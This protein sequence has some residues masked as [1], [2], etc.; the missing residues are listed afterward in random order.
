LVDARPVPPSRRL[1]N[2]LLDDP[3]IG[4]SGQAQ[5]IETHISWVILAEEYV[6]KIKKPVKL[7]FLDFSS[8]AARHRA[9]LEELRLNRRLLAEY[10]LDL[11]SIR[12]SDTKPALSGN[13]PIIDYAV[14]MRR[15]PPGAVLSP[16][17]APT[18]TTPEIDA[19]AELLAHFHAGLPVADPQAP[20]G[21]PE[22][23]RRPTEET[24]SELRALL[25]E[26]PAQA[27][28]NQIGDFLDREFERHEGLMDRRRLDGFVRECHGDLH[29]GNLARIE[30]RLVP[31]D[32]LEF[33]PGLRWID[34]LSEVAFLVM[35]L[36]VNR[37][38]HAGFRFLNRY[39]DV[40]GDY[41]GLPV[42]PFY[43]GYRAAVRAKV[44]A[45]G[46]DARSAECRRSIG[47]LLEYAANP[48]AGLGP[49]LV[50]VCGIS[51]SGKSYLAGR[52]A[53]AMPAIHVRS[54]VERKR[55]FGLG[56][57]A[58]T[59][60][61]VDGG[62]YAPEASRRT[63]ERLVEVAASVLAARL[64]VI[65]DATQ[66]RRRHRQPFLSLAQTLGVPSVILTCYCDP[67]LLAERVRRRTAAGHDPS[68]ADYGIALRQQS[69]FETPGDDEASMV[70]RLDTGTGIDPDPL[71]SR[72][73]QLVND[74][75]T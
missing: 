45:L 38:D 6:Y 19:L 32:A 47:Q 43:L 50:L 44:G 60:A 65:V 75:A 58:R 70:L 12:G 63:Y 1:V 68:E 36:Q 64:P 30:G 40:T 33:D 9:C 69:E 39:L 13:G 24:V 10:Y 46:P 20:W 8:L 53:E 31:F 49:V 18:I 57:L 15:F 52:L 48:R 74:S 41:P 26:S 62:I 66:L 5:V 25:G 59:E 72:I 2:A 28:A 14:K 23:V 54:D 21:K 71:A 4:G 11:V 42:V 7:G 29:L 16:A 37:R 51:G 34:V 55:L 17:A 27:L 56:A 22:L 61:T 67:Q 73:L 3:A 35:D